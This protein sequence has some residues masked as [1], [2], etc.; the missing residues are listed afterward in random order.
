MLEGRAAAAAPA[1]GVGVP[2]LPPASAPR[3]PLPWIA[4]DDSDPDA[5]MPAHALEGDHSAAAMEIVGDGDAEAPVPLALGQPVDF[6]LFVRGLPLHRVG[7]RSDERWR[8]HNRLRV[9]CP[10]HDSCSRSRST[11]LL[12]DQL[13][14][15]AAVWYLSVWLDHA[16]L[17][18]DS[19]RRF[20]PTM[21]QMVVAKE[22]AE[23]A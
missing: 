3:L 12:V 23:G 9:D 16:H 4:G 11:Q 21:E 7:G 14:D 5:A 6:P 18:A 1:A 22:V 10:A 19:H 17:D 8:Y 13:G 20:K 15:L 2:A